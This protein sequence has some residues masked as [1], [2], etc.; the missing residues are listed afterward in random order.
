MPSKT[1]VTELV[2]KKKET[3][4]GKRRKKENERR[5]TVNFFTYFDTPA[6]D[7]PKKQANSKS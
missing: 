5:G 4:R 7:A 2:R 1:A 3:K 6:E